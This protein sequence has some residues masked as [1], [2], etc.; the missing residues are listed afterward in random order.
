MCPIA[1]C[2]GRSLA[3]RSPP[4]P[5]T[6][7]HAGHTPPPGAQRQSVALPAP[8][9]QPRGHARGAV[10]ESPTR[11]GAGAAP[12]FGVQADWLPPHGLPVVGPGVAGG[13]AGAGAGGAPGVTCDFL[14][15]RREGAVEGRRRG[16][17]QKREEREGEGREV[18]EGVRGCMPDWCQQ[19]GAGAV[20]S[21]GANH[22]D[23]LCRTCGVPAHPVGPS[24][25]QVFL[26]DVTNPQAR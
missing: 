4:A 20:G 14:Q 10:G 12:R 21:V 9:A 1:I 8:H 18:H 6:R 16:K 17:R 11:A 25:A 5:A 13:A 3:I 24:A 23:L 22:A 19:L 2:C 26:L 7:S 15:G